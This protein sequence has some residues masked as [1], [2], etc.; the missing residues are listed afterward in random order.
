[1]TA[2]GG[3]ARRALADDGFGTPEEAAIDGYPP[4]ANARAVSVKVRGDQ[5]VVV[6]DTD[7]AYRYVV[8]LRKEGDLWYDEWDHN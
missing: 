8:H 6:V 3:N 1:V 4:S 5:A 7:P 2:N